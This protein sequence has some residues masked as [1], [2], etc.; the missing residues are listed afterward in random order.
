MWAIQKI[1]QL[2]AKCDFLLFKIQ[3]PYSKAKDKKP[4]YKY[5]DL[6]S[7][8]VSQKGMDSSF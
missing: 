5:Y 2:R 3:K 6:V 4:T 7:K 8:F 1:I